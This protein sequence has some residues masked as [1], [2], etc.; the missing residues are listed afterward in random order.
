MVLLCVAACSQNAELE[1]KVADLQTELANTRKELDQRMDEIQ[2]Q[3]TQAK[4]LEKSLDALSRE[5]QSL[6]AQGLA[7]PTYTPPTARREP[8]RSKT[9]SVP[10]AGLPSIGPAD[11]K[12][13]LVKNYEYACPYCEK[14]RDTIDQ[15]HAKYG[16]DLRIV[17]KPFVVHPQNATAS[18]LAA[19]AA[20]RQ[21]KFLQMDRL[22]WEQG[23]KAR[24]FDTGGAACLT[25]ST[26]CPIVEGFAKSLG[27]DVKKFRADMQS[28]QQVLQ[29]S[30]RELQTLGI[31]ATPTFF[32][33]GRF[34]SGAM[35]IDSFTVL[36]DEELAKANQRI[37]QGT[38]KSQYYDQW[39]L[40]NGQ[41]SLDP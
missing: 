17:F 36:I 9:Y 2:T 12:V 31:A 11:A 38:S 41:K 30:M 1:K 8:D 7:R 6:K 33:N 15:L 40:Q 18:S 21:H 22:L 4:Y 10:I 20:D 27:L 35:P 13:T 5:V 23:F 16:N 3:T 25:S 28:C 32:I 39:V 29:E 14:N 34:M 37:Q 24:Q 26:G 19:C